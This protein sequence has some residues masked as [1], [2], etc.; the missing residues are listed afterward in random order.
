[1]SKFI[2]GRSVVEFAITTYTV[3]ESAGTV[4]LQLS[5]S[6]GL[7]GSVTVSWS[8]RDGSARY[9]GDF[10]QNSGVATFGNG[11]SSTTFS[12]AIVNDQVKY[13]MCGHYKFV[14]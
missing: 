13:L 6:V 11:Q 5:R 14:E 4:S 1:M 2:S 8:T 7:F 12:I 10:S 3:S 9:P